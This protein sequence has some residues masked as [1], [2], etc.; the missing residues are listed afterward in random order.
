MTTIST[1]KSIDTKKETV[2]TD[3]KAII[4]TKDVADQTLYILYAPTETGNQTTMQSCATNL[5][6]SEVEKANTGF[7][8]KYHVAAEWK[9]ITNTEITDMKT[10]KKNR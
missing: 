3:A 2:V 5:L 7:I 9:D 6:Q 8:H 4:D 10:R 1:D